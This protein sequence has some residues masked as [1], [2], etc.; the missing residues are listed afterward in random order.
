M[1][2]KNKFYKSESKILKFSGPC[3][4][5]GKVGHMV[6]K[7]YQRKGQE[8]K[9][10]RQSDVQAHL[11]EGNEAINVLL[12]EENF[13]ANETDLVLEIS[14]S[15]NFCANNEVFDDSEEPTD[16]ECVYIGNS[17]TIGVL[18]KGKVLPKLTSGKTLSLNNVFYV[19]SL[20]RNLVFGSLINKVGCIV[21]E[22]DKIFISR[23]GDF[24]GK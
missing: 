7:C 19:P 3:L 14:A 10:E 2:K 9:K 20:R 17:S 15:R 21:F 1:K 13:I 11:V 18:C 5:C 6:V 8:K 12:V 24:F 16:G 4:I 23:R 22:D